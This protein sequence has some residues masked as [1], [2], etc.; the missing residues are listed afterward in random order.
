MKLFVTV[1]FVQ[2]EEAKM[3]LKQHLKKQ[4]ANEIQ[5]VIN[6]LNRKGNKDA[7]STLFF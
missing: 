2:E 4:G 7:D 5:R 1:V 6:N 3:K